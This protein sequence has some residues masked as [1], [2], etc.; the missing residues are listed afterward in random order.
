MLFRSCSLLVLVTLFGLFQS[1][2]AAQTAGAVKPPPAT[3]N[4]KP[5]SSSPTK[6]PDVAHEN[7]APYWTAELG[8]HT[9][10]QLRNNLTQRDL[11]VTPVLHLADGRALQLSPVTIP[12][13]TAVS[14]QVSQ[15]LLRVA[16]ELVDKLD[17]FGSLSF[18]YTSPGARNLYASVM[19]HTDRQPIGY[20]VDAFPLAKDSPAGSRE[21]IWWLPYSQ[22][23]DFLVLSN[24]A[25]QTL[26]GQLSLYDATGKEWQTS[27]ELAAYQSKR[28]VIGEL[29]RSAGLSG[30]YGGIK[31]SVPHAATAVSS[32]HFL[33]DPTVGFSALLKMFDRDPAASLD[34][35]VWAGNHQWTLWAPMLALRSPDP[36]V[37]FPQ[38]TTLQPTVLVHNTTAKTVTVNMALDWRGDSGK[39]KAPPQL[40]TLRPFET[41]RL[42]IGPMQKQLAIPDDAHWALVTLTT[43]ASPDDLVAVTA[44]YDSIGRYGAQTPFS[45]QLSEHWAGGFWQVDSTHSSI[46]AVTNG[47]T[48]ETDSLLTLFYTDTKQQPQK[49]EIKQTIAPGDQLW[50]NL[51][52]LIKYQVPDRSG[53]LLPVSLTSG[54]YELLDLKPGLGHGGN[55]FEGK[56]I[57]DKTWGHLSYGCMFCCGYASPYYLPDPLAMALQSTGVPEE[58][59]TD[60]CA[61]YD[62]QINFVTRWW[63]DNANV[64]TVQQ[65]TVTAAGVGSTGNYGS[66]HLATGDGLVDYGPRCPFPTQ[67]AE[68]AVNVRPIIT[69]INPNLLNAGDRGQSVTIH[70]AGFGSSPTVTLPSGVSA[71][72]QQDSTASTIVLPNVS[73]AASTEIGPNNITVTAGGFTSDPSPFTIDGPDHMIVKYDQVFPCSGCIYT[74][75]RDVTYQVIKFSGSPV[76]VIPIGESVSDSGWNCDQP[77]PG[78]TTT[79]CAGGLDTDTN[80][81]FTDS[82]TLRNDFTPSGCGTNTVDRWQWCAAPKTIG[83]LT[84]YLHTDDISI[85]GYVNPPNQFPAN[86]PI[87]P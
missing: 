82:W 74:V 5:A 9:E 51:G 4:P 69:S 27:V 19:V 83:T 80:G 33:Y 54:T 48:Q 17:T 42:D 1:P 61:G 75:E 78:A 65:G 62:T 36:A 63:T 46:L 86:Y 22:T 73:V 53:R 14:V 70:G 68:N 59:A 58:W 21:G 18:L 41:L 23:K 66:G 79:P 64:A 77:F 47:G 37:G 44:S 87:Y 55:L 72:N 10:L 3:N 16:P 29:V 71:N 67:T 49:Y 52:D 57:V 6:R 40:L 12:S 31:F 39:G 8:W 25:D 84:G 2:A 35:R 38:G 32:L 85:N 50:L 11:T 43:T 45:D 60:S 13:A 81:M 24:G 26:A 20:H 7:F 15:E 30:N 28:L 56:I 76:F 34:S